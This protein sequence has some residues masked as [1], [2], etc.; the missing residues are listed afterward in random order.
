G[1]RLSW[2]LIHTLRSRGYNPT[3]S[4]IV[5]TGRAARK[6]ARALH[7]VSWMGIK[8]VGC[9][10]ERPGALSSDLDLLG[11]LTDLP[12]RTHKYRASPA[13]IALPLSRCGDARRV[14]AVLSQLVVDVRLVADVPNLAGLSLTTTNLGGLPLL[15]LRESPPFGL[16]VVV[17]RAMDVV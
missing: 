4:I 11:G 13:F 3:Y 12:A 6:M 15:G 7:K 8:N 1:R 17:K 9:V 10:E 5:G 16:N 14:F 2:G